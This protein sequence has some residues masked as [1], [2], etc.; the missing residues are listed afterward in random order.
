MEP[1]TFFHSTKNIPIPSNEEYLKILVLKIESFIRRLRWHIFH[2]NNSLGLNL[3]KDNV[4]SGTQEMEDSVEDPK[5]KFGFK[6]EGKPPFIPDLGDFERDL[7]N[8]PKSIE[9]WN[10][11]RSDLQDDLNKFIGD[12]KKSKLISECCWVDVGNGSGG[13]W[14]S[15]AL[16]DNTCFECHQGLWRQF[17]H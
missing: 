5:P 2:V 1:F 9:F 10:V 6:C 7:L 8:I 13:G 14:L 12:L 16:V 4:N 15:R 11:P 3:L 17:Q